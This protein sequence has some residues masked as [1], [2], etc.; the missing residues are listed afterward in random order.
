MLIKTPLVLLKD[1]FRAG[2]NL[3]MLFSPDSVGTKLYNALVSVDLF[4]IW[5]FIVAG[6]GLAILYK[7]STKKGISIAF[8]VWLLMTLVTF[9]SGYM[10]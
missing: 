10:S 9:F 7:F 6:I 2:I 8:V 3:G 5:H 1:D 4:G